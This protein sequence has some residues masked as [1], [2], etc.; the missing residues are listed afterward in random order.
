MNLVLKP[1]LRMLWRDSS[2]VQLGIDARHAVRLEGLSPGAL[3]VLSLLDGSRD[4]DTVLA[5]AHG[6]GVD[7][8][9]VA[10]L[11]TALADQRLL[12]DATARLA[13]DADRLL[14]DLAHLSLLA[15]EPGDAAHRLRERALRTVLVVGAGRVGAQVAALLAAA[16]VGALRVL[17]P[18]PALVSD[19]APGGLLPADAGRARSSAAAAAAIRAGG[20]RVLASTGEP[21]EADLY[22]ADLTVVA[23]DCYDAVSPALLGLL[24]SLGARHLLAG[25]RDTAGI[26]GPLV[27]PGLTAC[28]RCLDLARAER[29]PGWPAV[30][31][32]LRVPAGTAPSACDVALATAVAGLAAGQALAVL[33]DAATALAC[34]DA[35]LELRL[36]E[37]S[38]RR[39]RW[40]AHPDC[41]C[42]PAAVA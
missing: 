12:D 30:S 1:A 14:P 38:L 39:R 6:R 27:V 34:V 15:D 18:R 35:T 26:V 41:G 16:G 7:P 13:E 37:G 3:T 32:Q 8:A 24:R 36:A 11:L 17:D 5:D 10:A 19:A 4:R 28:V 23:P 33:D 40:R 21:C 20:R 29:D 31:A 22:G 9:D 25:V 2:T 42:A